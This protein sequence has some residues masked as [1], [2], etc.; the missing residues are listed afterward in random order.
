MSPYRAFALIAG[1]LSAAG[2]CLA[3][4]AISARSGLIQLTVGSVYLQDK[5][6]HKTV[7]NML[8]VKQSEVL[9]TGPD[10]YAEVLL[11]PGVFLRLGNSTSFRMDSDALAHTHL[12]MLAGSAMLEC[13]ELLPDN[14]VSFDVGNK[15]VELRK[16]GL[17]RLEASPAAVATIQGEL[18]VAGNVGTTVKKGRL[19]Q[20]DSAVPEPVKFHN[21]KNDELYTF[22]KA[23]SEDSAYATGV[24][25][26]SLL[27]SGYGCRGGSSWYLMGGVGMYSYLPCSG[28][29]S[30]AFGYSFIGLNNGYMWG[31]PNY[32][33]PP[34]G[35]L[36]YGAGYGGYGYVPSGGA[37]VV[38]RGGLAAAAKPGA[39]NVPGRTSVGA[40]PMK[41][42]VFAGPNAM[43]NGVAPTA[44]MQQPSSNAS[45]A[46]SY[47]GA[48]R[49]VQP[50]ALSNAAGP[51]IGHVPAARG[52]SSGA[53]NGGG[54]PQR[55]YSGAAAAPRG[56]SGNAASM[57]RGSSGMS[58]GA[59]ARSAAGGGG[60]RGR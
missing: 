35:L 32:Y 8:Q 29:Y 14:N 58:A 50:R 44:V 18:F 20:F 3:Q 28:M 39:T 43:R 21:D 52:G 6:V 19:L 45:F 22:S 42:P 49:P 36:G 59:G 17:Y 12:T 60:T 37:A 1:T 34:Y 5:P 26:S 2:F 40:A 41:V 38:G 55:V 30:N 10:G 9:R 33:V 7:T 46:S 13:D 25:S 57:S 31:G 48:M 11:T 4:S 51:S 24:T 54:T 27:S 47:R 53:M 16:K 23:R 15:P 56:T